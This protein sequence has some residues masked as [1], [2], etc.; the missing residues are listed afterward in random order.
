MYEIK[1]I[2]HGYKWSPVKVYRRSIPN[3][4]KGNNWRLKVSVF[5]R[6][7]HKLDEP[8]NATLIITLA[9]SEHTAPVFNDFIVASRN[10]GWSTNDLMISERVRPRT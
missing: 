6:S 3:G 5:D 7:L 2:E 10:I 1:M 9:D 4:V 8:Q